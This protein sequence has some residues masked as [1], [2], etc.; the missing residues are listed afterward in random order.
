MIGMKGC[1][2]LAAVFLL[3]GCPGLGDK[4]VSRIPTTITVKDNGICVVS[5]MN[6]GEKIT[7]IQIYSDTGDKLIKTLDDMPEYSEKGKCL[8]VFGYIFQPKKHYSLAYDV[9]SLNPNDSHLI[10][11]EFSI[12][13]DARGNITLDK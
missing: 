4:V 9:N 2:L 1:F 6:P 13:S 11:A 5:P 10:T 8:P 3:A 7:A 12:S